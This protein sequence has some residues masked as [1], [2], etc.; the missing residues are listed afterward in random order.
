MWNE[1]L[2]TSSSEKNTVQ[3][4]RWVRWLYRRLLPLSTPHPSVSNPR[5]YRRLQ[6][7]AI[8]CLMNTTLSFAV[9]FP[10]MGA[11][12]QFST[13]M[14]TFWSFVIYLLA[15]SRWYRLA[16]ELIFGALLLGPLLFTAFGR[17]EVLF[18]LIIVYLIA[19]IF[20]QKH[21]PLLS[22]YVLFGVSV[23]SVSMMI[24]PLQEPAVTFTVAIEALHVLATL[25]LVMSVHQGDLVELQQLVTETNHSA[26]Y[27]QALID[28]LPGMLYTVSPSYE[29]TSAYGTVS[30]HLTEK[31]QSLIG[32]RLDTELP[33][34]IW[35][36]V[37]SQFNTVLSQHRS[38]HYEL[39][40]PNPNQPSNWVENRLAPLIING[41]S[42]GVLTF[43]SDITSRKLVE[44][45]YS[46]NSNLL[47]A[48]LD[49]IMVGVFI[50]REERIV[51]HNQMVCA[52]TGFSD[53]ELQGLS[54]AKLVAP[55]LR[56]IAENWTDTN[57]N[58]LQLSQS[59]I[60]IQDRSGN[61]LWV[62]MTL[63][64]IG[65]NG[66]PAVI[67]AFVNATR[68][69]EMQRELLER[70]Q[71]FRSLIENST[72]IILV[73]NKDYTMR[74]ASP[75]V[76]QHL[77]FS[78]EV[79]DGHHFEDILQKYIHHDDQALIT[80]KMTGL[81]DQ[82]GIQASARFRIRD[83]QGQ[84]H[85]FEAVG[86]NMLDEPG[87]GAIIINAHDITQIQEALRA[88]REQRTLSEALLATAAALNSTLKLE[89]ILPYIL[90]N[91]KQIVPYERANIAL[92]Q[93]TGTTS[94]V[95]HAGYSPEHT[96]SILERPLRIDESVVYQRMITTREPIYIADTSDATVWV[97]IPYRDTSSYL[98]APIMLDD[99]VIGFL[100]LES[101]EANAFGEDAAT[102]LRL[103]T[104]HAALAIRN[105]RAYEQ[106]QTLA[107]TTERQRIAGELHDAVSQTLFSA[108]M[109]SETLPLLYEHQPEEVFDGLQELARLTKG[110][111]AEMRALLMELRPE[112]LS[113]TDLRTLLSHLING[114]RTRTDATIHQ[115]LNAATRKLPPDVRVNLY[116]IT[117]EAFNNIVRHAKATDIWVSLQA[118]DDYIQLQIRDNGRGF[119]PEAVTS[120]HMGLRIMRERARNNGIELLIE[121]NV[122]EG[123]MIQA[124]YPVV[125]TAASLLSSSTSED[126]VL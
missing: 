10:L 23:V 103:F 77:G 121:T 59:E 53:G 106:G 94:T 31:I 63:S 125:Q 24:S 110:A 84:W 93:D 109:I 105:A 116:R 88:E 66:K 39:E 108:S 98:G 2:L 48:V 71:H 112:T 40:L 17:I 89:E 96:R 104:N 111:L 122:A 57:G 50:Q 14:L 7:L 41:N 49:G 43:V 91:L 82:S 26:A 61:R 18:Q 95:S 12:T 9:L 114:F 5:L 33:P 102:K 62:N 37:R 100:N 21:F 80:E 73:L 85:W 3:P 30:N 101:S 11:E 90:E 65:Y 113:R 97:K 45:A 19:S 15:R 117:Q 120:E 54:L 6:A 32:K 4:S 69:I 29:V 38:V 74:Y 86:T 44:Q 1:Q 56:E 72:D 58:V 115:E 126:E 42:L 8:F 34:H 75:A 79:C 67:V 78:R 107:A 13:L 68:N 118:Q 52:L 83:A 76:G 81:F 25:F 16:I 36:V 55:E 35:E 92:V 22:L 87:I 20:V 70:E 46:E 124:R 60:P 123:T 51:F 119:V 99:D 47:Q 28:N 64:P 27:Q